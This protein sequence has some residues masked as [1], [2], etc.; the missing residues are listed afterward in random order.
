MRGENIISLEKVFSKKYSYPIVLALSYSAAFYS[1]FDPIVT[2]IKSRDLIVS[3]VYVSFFFFVLILG[4]LLRPEQEPKE[5]LQRGVFKGVGRL[6]IDDAWTRP[7]DRNRLCKTIKMPVNKPILLVGSSGVGKSVLLETQITPLLRSEGWKSVSYTNYDSFDSFK[8]DLL[9]SLSKI[10]PGIAHNR[11]TSD[12]IL[13][14]IDNSIN[15]LLIYDQFEQF[16]S[17]FGDKRAENNEGREWF[18]NF[19]RA[20]TNLS[21]IRH[22]IVV[23]KEWYYDLRFLEEYIPPPYESYHLSGIKVDT[24]TTEQ[25]ILGSKMHSVTK[26]A[27][28][29]KAVLKSLIENDEILPVQA[30]IV[31]LM[32]EN[33]AK[34]IG[35]IDNE[36]YYKEFGGKDGLIQNYFQSY[37]DA[38]PNRQISLQVL[39]AMSVETRLRSQISL[40]HIADIIHKNEG[41][42]RRC[43][44]F[45]VDH[46]L[47]R[48]TKMGGYELAHD[49][50]AEK[51]HEL[52]GTELDPVERDNIL[53]FWDEMRKAN[54]HLDVTRQRAK[55]ESKRKFVF[56]DFFMGFLVV[57]LFA[58]LF[59]PSYESNWGWFN[60]LRDY[61]KSN[62]GIDIYY[63]PVFVSHLAWSIYVT[64]FYRRFFSQ[65]R[66]K[67]LARVLSKFTVVLCTACVVTAVFVP[68]FWLFSIGI[69]GLGIGLKL[70]QLAKS[71]GLSKISI[72]FFSRIAI[73]TLIN[74]AVVVA[75]GLA[76]I[77]YV[78]SAL[79]TQ[80]LVEQLNVFFYFISMVMTYY[81]LAVR[82]EHTT[83]D[84]ASKMLGL[85]DRGTVRLKRLQIDLSKQRTKE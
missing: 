46:G 37:M 23:R 52:S 40:P 19:L 68:Y 2:A 72:D 45:F 54:G 47:V 27:E 7:D 39:C 67:S 49:Y 60:I 65:L 18:K 77:Y 83:K 14:G 31:G 69:G 29:A 55:D 51:F 78:H 30:Q 79:L 76:V 17:V 32:L 64:L 5:P 34:E 3:G 85:V 42:V 71:P 44:S 81:M 59:A 4:Y 21:N 74:L 20:S 80:T 33:K 38:S 70:L 26:N 82:P 35:I 61:Q 57:L 25:L 13:E 12:A 66:E 58:R 41:E 84:A 11:F 48:E 62:I 73:P 8:N 53:F 6:E 75:V 50:L 36:C 28:T 22:L 10:F 16:L 9:Q 15:L 43:L 56:S 63:L 24:N 1:L